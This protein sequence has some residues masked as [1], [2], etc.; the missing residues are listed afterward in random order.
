M[1]TLNDSLEV[2][3]YRGYKVTEPRRQVLAVLEQSSKPLSAYDIQKLL[4]IEGKPLNPV[5]IYRVLSLFCSLNLAHRVW[6]QGGFIKCTLDEEEGCHR[7]VV[8]RR[9]GSLQEFASK[10]LCEE[11]KEITQNLGFHTEYHLS[12]VFGLCSRCHEGKE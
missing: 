1:S 2:L 8:C 7:F 5:T 10:A 4:Q 6:S 9:C 11:E 12:E 3:R